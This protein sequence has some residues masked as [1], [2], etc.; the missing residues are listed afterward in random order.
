[1]MEKEAKRAVSRDREYF[2]EFNYH[3]YFNKALIMCA[4]ET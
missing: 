2:Y 1:M 4:M 3:A